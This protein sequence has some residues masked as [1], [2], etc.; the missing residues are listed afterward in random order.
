MEKR[1]TSVSFRGGR[2]RMVQLSVRDR[3]LVRH[4]PDFLFVFLLNFF[5]F[6]IPK[7]GMVA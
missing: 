3:K 7:T 2:M 5:L 6:L 1:L 4:N